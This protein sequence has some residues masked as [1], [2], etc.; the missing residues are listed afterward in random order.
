[1]RRKSN[2]QEG[3]KKKDRGR[4]TVLV[5]VALDYLLSSLFL[6]WLKVRSMA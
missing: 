3:Y 5:M 1:M 2:I 6:S 4:E